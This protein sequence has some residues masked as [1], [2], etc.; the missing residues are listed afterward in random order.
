VVGVEGGSLEL[1][2]SFLDA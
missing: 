2:L 1:V